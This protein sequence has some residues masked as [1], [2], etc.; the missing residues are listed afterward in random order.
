MVEP[1]FTEIADED[2]VAVLEAALVSGGGKV[3]RETDLYMCSVAAEHLAHRLAVA[4]LKVV[5]L[6]QRDRWMTK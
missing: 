5:R 1:G 6:R 3:T 2:L 4:G